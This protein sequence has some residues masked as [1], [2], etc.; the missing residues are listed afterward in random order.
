MEKSKILCGGSKE[1][2]GLTDRCEC[3]KIP[4]VLKNSI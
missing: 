2:R 3:V 1:H 4:I